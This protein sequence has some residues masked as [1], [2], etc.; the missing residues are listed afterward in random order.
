[1]ELI[2]QSFTVQSADE[3][4]KFLLSELQEQAI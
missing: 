3:V 4:K 2:S 1:M